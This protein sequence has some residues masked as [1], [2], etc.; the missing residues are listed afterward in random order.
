MLGESEI[1]AKVEVVGW[2]L[3]RRGLRFLFYR[4]VRLVLEGLLALPMAQA[5][6]R[7]GTARYAGL[8]LGTGLAYYF[9][10]QLL[11]NVGLVAQLPALG[12]AF[13]PPLLLLGLVG[14]VLRP[15]T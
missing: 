9:L 11:S 12:V 2:C 6:A 1:K 8:A 5:T 14:V 10:E 4:H 3:L 13:L 7:Q 15:S